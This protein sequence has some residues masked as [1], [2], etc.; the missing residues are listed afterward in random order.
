MSERHTNFISKSFA[1]VQS[2][3]CAFD[4]ARVNDAIL[5]LF[6]SSHTMTDYRTRLGFVVQ[7]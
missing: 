5:Y 6:D 4:E 1:S 3:V 2:H 7:V